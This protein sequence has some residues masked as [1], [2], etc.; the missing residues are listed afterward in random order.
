MISLFLKKYLHDLRQGSG[1]REYI[2]CPS[3]AV[4]IVLSP[5]TRI[6]QI[7]KGVSKELKST[8]CHAGIA[9]A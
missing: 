3:E 4:H 6:D 7:N 1:D 5:R 8:A 9:F 2:V